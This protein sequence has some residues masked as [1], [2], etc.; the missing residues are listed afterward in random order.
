MK[1][2]AGI[3]IALMMI[4]LFTAPASAGSNPVLVAVNGKGIAVYTASGGSKQAGILYNGYNTEL[5]LEPKNG[6]YSCYLTVDY[7]VWMDQKKAESALPDG[8]YAWDYYEASDQ[9]PC[10]LF[11][12]EVTKED[13]PLYSTPGHKHLN[14]RHAPGTLFV[15]CGEFGDD[16]YVE[17]GGISGF[18]PKTALKKVKDLT[19]R[20]AIRDDLGIETAQ[21]CTVYTGGGMIMRGDS[22]TGYSDGTAYWQLHDGDKVTVLRVIGDTAQLANGGF[23]ETRF[24]DPEGDH[25][26]TYAT[27]KTDGILNRLNVRAYAGTDAFI[28]CKLCSGAQVQVINHTDDWASVLFTGEAGSEVYTGVVMTKYLTWDNESPLNGMTRV[29]TLC[30]LNTYA[31]GSRYRVSFSA[32]EVMAAG[33]ELTVVG[34]KANPTSDN[35]MPDRFLCLTEEGRLIMIYDDGVLEPIETSGIFARAASNVRFRQTPDKNAAVLGMIDSGAKVEILL[36]GEGWTMVKYKGKT[37]Y[38]MS[39]YLKFP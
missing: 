37:G 23:I 38:V 39:R 16:Y 1:R 11:L 27:V 13:A 20:E 30:P 19:F 31:G 36:R 33:T 9:V 4:I 12:A 10:S 2:F 34:V 28:N 25:S 14:A 35:D 18:M 15:V 3:L 32:E 8:V 29:R 22:V 26:R 21:V 24:L 17:F 5:S 6:L 7:S